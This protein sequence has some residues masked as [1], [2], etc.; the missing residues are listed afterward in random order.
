M[1]SCLLY[2]VKQTHSQRCRPSLLINK[3]LGC[4]ELLRYGIHF[5]CIYNDH[6]SFGLFYTMYKN[7]LDLPSKACCLLLLGFFV[8]YINIYVSQSSTCVIINLRLNAT[9]AIRIAPAKNMRLI[10]NQMTPHVW[11]ERPHNF[12]NLDASDS[13]AFRKTRSS[14][15]SH[16][17]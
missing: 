15:I 17:Q 2:W 10:R 13:Y 8:L 3:T 9:S 12:A 11:L 4:H 14:R 16:K 7:L 5:P 1:K 6:I